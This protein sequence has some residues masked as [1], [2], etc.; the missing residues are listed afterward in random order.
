MV[1]LAAAMAMEEAVIVV[2][3]N[4]DLCVADSI[5]AGAGAA[6]FLDTGCCWA[7]RSGGGGGGG[8]GGGDIG[9]GG[10]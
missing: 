5:M 4:F 2:E 9:L 10:W 1:V 8:G 6:R 3:D 7:G